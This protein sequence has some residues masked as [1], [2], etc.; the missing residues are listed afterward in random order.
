MIG[1]SGYVSGLNPTWSAKPFSVICV[2]QLAY[3]ILF[4]NNCRAEWVA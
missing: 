2:A 1:G 3:A 4:G